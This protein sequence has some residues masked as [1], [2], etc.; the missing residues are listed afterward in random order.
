MLP[1]APA[2]PG[3]TTRRV[4]PIQ[5]TTTAP[6]RMRLPICHFTQSAMLCTGRWRLIGC[7]R[8]KAAVSKMP[9]ADET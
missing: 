4:P 6:G 5:G 3:A 1:V 7:R 2:M 8:M 9:I